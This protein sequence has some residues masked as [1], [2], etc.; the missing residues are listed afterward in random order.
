MFKL[1]ELPEPEAG[2]MPVL[3]GN[4]ILHMIQCMAPV[5]LLSLHSWASKDQAI[6]PSLF[7]IPKFYSVSRLSLIPCCLTTLLAF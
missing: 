7:S 4:T 3:L 5:N 1:S 6:S 2:I